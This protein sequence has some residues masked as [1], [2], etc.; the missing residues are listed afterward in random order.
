MNNPV[1]TFCPWF[2]QLTTV[3]QLNF[4]AVKF[5]EFGPF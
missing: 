1:Y 5:R 4:A 2:I 3:N